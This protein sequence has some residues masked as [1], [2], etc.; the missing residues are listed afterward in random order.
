MALEYTICSAVRGRACETNAGWRGGGVTTSRTL[1][2]PPISPVTRSDLPLIQDLI[3]KTPCRP[4]RDDG[5]LCLG[6][7][8]LED[9]HGLPRLCGAPFLVDEVLGLV[10]L[11]GATLR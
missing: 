7:S 1:P 11:I 10:A 6:E 4:P 8:V 2:L 3:S 9:N 5:Y